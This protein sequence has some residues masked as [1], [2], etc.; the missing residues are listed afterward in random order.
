HRTVIAGPVAAAPEQER[1]AETDSR[2]TGLAHNLPESIRPSSS[3]LF[4]LAEDSGSAV[5]SQSFAR[6]RHKTVW[7][8]RVNEP[9]DCDVSAVAG[10]AIGFPDENRA[11]RERPTRAL[12]WSQ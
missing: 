6:H 5:T 4:A 3:Q 10:A 2:I 1:R 7:M 9:F 12:H 8:L 11:A